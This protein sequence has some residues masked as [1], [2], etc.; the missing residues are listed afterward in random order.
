MVSTS[1]QNKTTVDSKMLECI[2]LHKIPG[3]RLAIIYVK[4]E[5]NLKEFIVFRFK[6][7][8]RTLYE[9]QPVYTSCDFLD[10]SISPQVDRSYI[11]NKKPAHS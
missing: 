10:L 4:N 3:V 5:F 1:K 11:T 9:N 8:F 6:L 7:M 2:H